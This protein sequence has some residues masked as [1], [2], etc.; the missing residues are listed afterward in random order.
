MLKVLTKISMSD[1]KRSNLENKKKL[2]RTHYDTCFYC[3]KQLGGDVELDHFIPW[4][5]TTDDDLSNLVL[6]CRKCNAIKGR[7]YEDERHLN[8]ICKRK[9]AP[10]ARTE[11]PFWRVR[12]ACVHNDV[13]QMQDK[14][15]DLMKRFYQHSYVQNYRSGQDS[16][17]PRSSD[18]RIWGAKIIQ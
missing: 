11:N 13:Q 10:A 6:S 17:N 2:L 3:C 14:R 18:H 1:T 7:S 5:D 8:K 15:G 16:S 9:Q 12:R 4:V